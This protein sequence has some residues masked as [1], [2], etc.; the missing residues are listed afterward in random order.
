MNLM[1]QKFAEYYYQC[2]NATLSAEQAG[3]SSKT[4]YSQGQRLLKNVEV[5]AYI[6]ELSEKEQNERIM[7]A[8][9]RQATLS[10]IAR[11][12]CNAPTERIR[13]IDT[14]NKMTGEYTVK[15]DIN[16]DTELNVYVDYGDGKLASVFEQFGG[17]GLEE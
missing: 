3:Y 8:A 14:L 7:T 17:K 16:T 6:Q 12:E 13:A 5:S 2:G 4:A 1:Q 10:D 9:E 11:N 15:A